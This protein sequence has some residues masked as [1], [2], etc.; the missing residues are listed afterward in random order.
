MI[1]TDTCLMKLV[2]LTAAAGV[3]YDGYHVALKLLKL[4]FSKINK[5]NIRR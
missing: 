3:D 5:W 2:K 4:Y 1:E